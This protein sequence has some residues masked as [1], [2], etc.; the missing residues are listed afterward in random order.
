MHADP[1]PIPDPPGGMLHPHDGRQAVLPGDHCAMG[2]QDSHLRHEALKLDE[3]MPLESRRPQTLHQMLFPY[4]QVL[5]D[6]G[7]KADDGCREAA[8]VRAFSLLGVFGLLAGCY[9]LLLVDSVRSVGV[10]P[11]F[12]GVVLFLGSTVQ[13][14]DCTWPWHAAFGEREWRGSP[15][16]VASPPSLPPRS[17]SNA[18]PDSTT[19][20]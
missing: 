6:S 9:A 10:S 15:S 19:S 16:P 1:L 14:G 3:Y 4:T 2:H 11:G 17:S 13:S 8:R 18:P 7:R 12:L 5:Y 20:R